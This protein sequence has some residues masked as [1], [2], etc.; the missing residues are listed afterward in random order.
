M[1]HIIHPVV[2]NISIF[3]LCMSN[4]NNNNIKKTSYSTVL[5]YKYPTLSY[6][7]LLSMFCKSPR[8][9]FINQ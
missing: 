5:C 6:G 7:T 2:Y 3:L 8:F 4:K 9:V 1:L